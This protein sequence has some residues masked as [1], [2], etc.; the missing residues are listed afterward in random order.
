MPRPTQITPAIVNEWRRLQRE[1]SL[2]V[3]AAAERVGYSLRGLYKAETALGATASARPGAASAKRVKAKRRASAG[4]RQAARQG[5]TR[6]RRTERD[7]IL[8]LEDTSDILKD[9]IDARQHGDTRGLSNLVQAHVRVR[10]AIENMRKGRKDTGSELAAI[11][12]K[13]PQAIEKIR[14]GRRMLAR[15][16]VASG[17]CA[18]CGGK[19]SDEQVAERKVRAA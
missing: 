2:D 3:E 5:A 11:M 8:D 14:A 19:L 9:S 17:C 18:A 6:A 7:S 15:Q 12:A 10:S 1:E 13:G 16:E 4:A